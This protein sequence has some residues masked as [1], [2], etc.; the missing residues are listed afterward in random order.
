MPAIMIAQLVRSWVVRK[1]PMVPSK[2][3]TCEVARQATGIAIEA[4]AVI[5]YDRTTSS[6]GQLSQAVIVIRFN[7]HSSAR[8]VRIWYTIGCC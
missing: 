5:T 3:S 7:T 6:L 1:A 2:A 4:S 8:N